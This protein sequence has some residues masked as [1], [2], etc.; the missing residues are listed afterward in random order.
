MMLTGFLVFAVL[1]AQAQLPPSQ[2]RVEAVLDNPS[3]TIRGQL[4]ELGDGSLALTVKGKRLDVPM[5]RVVRVDA[6]PRDSVRNGALIGAVALGAWC[7]YI[8]AQ[9]ADRPTRRI[10]TFF[11]GALSGAVIGALIDWRRNPP[12]RTIYSR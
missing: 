5:A 12:R 9:G 10:S 6:V 7:A 4:L 8:C 1:L 2:P 11:G 3:Q